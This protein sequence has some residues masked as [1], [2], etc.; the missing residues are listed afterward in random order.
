MYLPIK[1]TTNI[2]YLNRTKSLFA[3]I[4][5][6]LIVGVA[7]MGCQTDNSPKETLDPIAEQG[8]T[9]FRNNCA[10]CHATKGETIIVGPSL[11][12]IATRAET[13]EV[14]LTGRQ[15]ILISIIKPDAYI[16]EGYQDLMP[17][18][19]GTKFT[20]EELDALVMYLLTLD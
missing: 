13:S 7:L 2:S 4:L 5:Y 20:G 1:K 12:G 18:N 14:G 16:V 17:S 8:K 11:A 15:Y 10:S 19:Y 6:S 3:I 9:V